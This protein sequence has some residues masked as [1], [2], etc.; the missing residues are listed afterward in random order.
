MPDFAREFT[1]L[2]ARIVFIERRIEGQYEKLRTCP[3]GS[4]SAL[5]AKAL[6]GVLERSLALMYRRRDRLERELC[7]YRR[8]QMRRRTPAGL[9]PAGARAV[10]SPRR[11]EARMQREMPW[12]TRKSQLSEQVPSVATSAPTWSKPA[13]M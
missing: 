1:D 10:V 6:T 11:M 2:C 3:Q 12:A 7:I 8:A 5:Y 9:A 13:R 4:D